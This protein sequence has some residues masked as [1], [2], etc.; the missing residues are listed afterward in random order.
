[1][2]WAK[3]FTYVFDDEEWGKKVLIG[4]ILA[5]IP[6]VNLVTVGYGLKVLKNVAEGAPKPLPE[7]DDFGDYFVKGLMSVL[8]S[9]IWAIPI[10]LLA[11]ATAALSALT[12]YDS[13]DTSSA[14]GPF[15]VCIWGMSCLSG[16]YGLFLGLVL[17]AAHAL[18][19]VKGDFGAFFRFGEIH[20]FIKSNLGNYIIALLLLVV[21]VFVA[22]FGVILCFVGVFFTLFWSGLVGSHLLGQLHHGSTSEP[23]PAV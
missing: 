22:K 4:G 21:A 16:I 14:A 11:A 9:M 8:A 10:I 15:V 6:I 7:W 1:M 13:A 12:G 5:L 23:E 19:A 18:Y 17:P 2:D 3:A 20:R